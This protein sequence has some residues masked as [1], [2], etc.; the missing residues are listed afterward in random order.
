MDGMIRNHGNLPATSSSS[1]SMLSLQDPDRQLGT[2]ELA[3]FETPDSSLLN[4]YFGYFHSAHP[5]VLPLSVLRRYLYDD[6]ARLLIQVVSYIG[7]LFAPH[8][9]SESHQDPLEA[10]LNDVRSG[11]RATHPFDVQAVLLYSIAIYWRHER[12]EGTALLGESVIMAIRLGMHHKSF[13]ILHGQ[14]DATLEES[15][16]RTWWQIFIADMHLAGSAHEMTSRTGGIDMTVDLP[17]EESDYEAGVWFSPA[18]L[19]SGFNG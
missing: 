13:A 8:I 1:A 11:K 3:K 5:C 12:H 16:R 18:K 17:C 19:K 7:S 14:G 15:W 2:N 9:P 6:R 10:T 4:L